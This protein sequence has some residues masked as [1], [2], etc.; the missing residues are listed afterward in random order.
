MDCPDDVSQ[1]N[2][3]QIHCQEKYRQKSGLQQ[4]LEGQFAGRKKPTFLVIQV[5]HVQ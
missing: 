3:C 1:Y 2:W 5:K 4:I